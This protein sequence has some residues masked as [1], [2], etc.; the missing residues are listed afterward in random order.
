MI[1]LARH[2]GAEPGLAAISITVR[3]NAFGSQAESFESDV[4]L[5]GM[6]EGPFRAVFIRAPLIQDAD[7]EILARVDGHPI[8]A[9]EG[10]VLVTAFHPE[11]TDDDRLHRLWLAGVGRS[12]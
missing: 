4:E 10:N 7:A 6:S 9:R 1:L 12:E 11:L 8:A 5:T 2:D 3:R